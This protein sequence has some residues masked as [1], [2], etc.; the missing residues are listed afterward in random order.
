MA[1]DFLLVSWRF[2]RGLSGID[3]GALVTSLPALLPAGLWRAKH[4][5]QAELGRVSVPAVLGVLGVPGVPAC[6]PGSRP[7]AICGARCAGTA[8]RRP[9]RRAHA[10][11]GARFEVWG[12]R[13][14]CAVRRYAA[15]AGGTRPAVRGAWRAVRGAWR[16][17]RGA[18]RPRAVRDA[19][20][21][22]PGARRVRVRCAA[23]A[24]GARYAVRGATG[25]MV[26]PRGHRHPLPWKGRPRESARHGG[27]A[28]R[29]RR[30]ARARTDAR[31]GFAPW[32]RALC[33]ALPRPRTPQ[34]P[35]QHPHPEHAK[36]PRPPGSTS[37]LT[38]RT[39][40]GP[41]RNAGTRLRTARAHRPTAGLVS[42]GFYHRPR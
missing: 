37:V 1:Q 10:A 23:C 20:L 9:V 38:E 30:A 19:R 8:G 21:V 42:Q 24:C 26:I 36:C 28:L 41:R 40:A 16:A 2:P 31:Y 17:V 15:C 13:R 29:G 33:G 39:D 5:K 35:P 22:L 34:Q 27:H 25:R 6:S 4:G 18:W 14:S 7:S 3:R 32:E 11:R 12:A